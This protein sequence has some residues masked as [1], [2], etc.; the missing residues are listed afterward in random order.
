MK[1]TDLGRAVLYQGDC[2]NTME[3]I[4]DGSVDGLII[5]PP[6][7][8]G[9]T[10]STQRKVESGKKYLDTGGGKQ[11]DFPNFSGDNMDMRSFTMFMRAVLF[12]GRQKTKENGVC[13]VFIDFR[14]L[15]AVADAMQMAGWTWRGI[16]V[17][18]KLNSRPQKGRFKNQC[19]YI[20][21]GSNGAMPPDRGVPVLEGVFRFQNVATATAHHQTEKPIGLMEKVVEI[22]PEGGTVLDCFMGSGSTG[23]ACIRTGRRFLGIELNEIYYATA[24][25]RIE[26]GMVTP[27]L[28][29][30]PGD[31]SLVLPKRILDGI[32]EMIYA[33][34]KIAPGTANDDTL[35]YGVEVKFYNMEVELSKDLETKYPGLYIIGDGS[36]VTHS[37]SHASASGVYV[38]RKIAQKAGK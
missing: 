36:G 33:L 31:L 20:V 25:K 32:I 38:A 18:D 2:I 23:V 14:N 11:T 26:E 34:D 7:S 24:I 16:A 21:W 5:D 6:Y 3:E 29:A 27:T 13:C 28:Q 9:G 10:F 22:V 19:E 37:L 30:T 15:P 12:E 1:R 4:P 8:S 35:L 17:W